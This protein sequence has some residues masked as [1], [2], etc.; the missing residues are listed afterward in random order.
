MQ[1]DYV[2][3][4]QKHFEESSEV[5]LHNI[6]LP[7]QHQKL[8]EALMDSSIKW[9]ISGPPNRRQKLTLFGP[10][11][12][13]TLNIFRH[14]QIAQCS[15]M[16]EC[17]QELLAALRSGPMFKLLNRLTDLDFDCDD[18]S[19]AVPLCSAEVQQWSQGCYTLLGSPNSSEPIGDVL[20]VY[21][22]FNSEML[23]N[24]DDVGGDICYLTHKMSK[25]KSREVSYFFDSKCIDLKYYFSPIAAEAQSCG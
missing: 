20:D 18:T 9:D 7:E 6:L 3:S 8:S 13:I 2:T 21:M 1:D 5:Q 24:D 10:H 25:Q 16:P 15:S 14:Y 22:H 19:G 12:K 4:I 17:V 11:H 23:P